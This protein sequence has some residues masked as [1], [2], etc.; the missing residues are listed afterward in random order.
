MSRRD[1]YKPI[2]CIE[3]VSVPVDK[4]SDYVEDIQDTINGFDTKAA[5]YGHASA[6]CLH[7]RPLIN[8][9]TNNGVRVMQELTVKAM[10]L[11]IKYG[12]VLSGEHGDGLQR[13]DL[14]EKL[15]GAKLYGVMK[16]IKS[17][18]DPENMFNPGKIVDAP[19]CTE[20][21]RYGK[22]YKTYDIKTYLDW[23]DDNGIAEASEMCSGQGVCRKIDEGIMCPS[24]I[25]THDEKDSTRA[26]AN[27]LRAVLSGRLPK[28]KLASKEM[29]DIFDLCI[30]CK[31]CKTECPSAVDGAKMKTEYLAYYNKAGG[32]SIRDRF[33]SNIHKLSD[34]ASRVAPV[35][36]LITN[37]IITKLVLPK[38][39][40]HPNRT[41][42]E[43]TKETYI[44]W[45][46]NRPRKHNK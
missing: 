13:S 37:N 9:K 32:V 1:S 8:L 17:I 41:L 29:H 4:L 26:R 27:A 24:Y 7:I 44:D 14:N 16:E 30:S 25:A 31:A 11:A 20:N 33:F 21:L 12:G 42:P 3:D 10:E 22:D 2:P 35:S 38:I 18:F 46:N 6:G 19:V 28:Q 39:G 23:N 43:I 34:A 15:F 45:F 5:F 36:N 40:I